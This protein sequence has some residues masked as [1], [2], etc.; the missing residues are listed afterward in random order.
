MPIPLRNLNI[1]LK[2]LAISLERNGLTAY[3]IFNKLSA[4]IHDM[5][6]LQYILARLI[7]DD[8]VNEMLYTSVSGAKS[9]AYKISYEGNL[10]YKKG[11][12]RN[13]F[14]SKSF[15]FSTSGS[16]ITK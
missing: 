6:E 15:L 1:V 2:F 13:S 16:S 3:E 11:G 14:F 8:F 4:D 9:V 10:Y 7:K 5:A 12:Y